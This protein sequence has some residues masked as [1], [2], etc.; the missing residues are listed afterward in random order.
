MYAHSGSAALDISY[1]ASGRGDIFFE[2][3]LSPWDHA[4]SSLILAEAG[5]VTE[6]LEGKVPS[7][8]GKSSIIASTPSLLSEIKALGLKGINL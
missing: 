6:T 5:G 2:F 3:Q 4:A 7:L 8:I 1:I